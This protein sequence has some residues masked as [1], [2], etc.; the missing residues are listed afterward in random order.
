MRLCIVVDF[1]FLSYLNIQV[2]TLD[3]YNYYQLVKGIFL[4]Y[5]KQAFH[6]FPK[7]VS[8]MLHWRIPLTVHIL[9]FDTHTFQKRNFIGS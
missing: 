5:F 8:E 7:R 1:P 3:S 9:S 4:T 2:K 6:A